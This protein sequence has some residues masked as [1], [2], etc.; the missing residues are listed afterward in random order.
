MYIG[1]GRAHDQLLTGGRA[2][3]VGTNSIRRTYSRQ[4]GL[5]YIVDN[6]G[7]IVNAVS[8]QVWS[9]D[10]VVHV[11]IVNWIKGIHVGLKTLAV[12]K[13]DHVASQWEVFHPARINSSLSPE[14]DLREARRLDSNRSTK[15]C[16]QGQTH[17]NN[18]FLIPADEARLLLTKYPEIP[19]RAFPVS[20]RKRPCCPNG[21]ASESICYRLWHIQSIRSEEILRAIRESQT[22]RS[23]SAHSIRRER[24]RSEREKRSH[25]TQ[26]PA[27][28][29]TM[30]NSSIVGGNYHTAGVA[31]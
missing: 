5:D 17:G 4:G 16:F 3:L 27:S 13:G 21:L 30:R 12:Q 7:A 14:I 28:T 1:F 22:R 29:L 11:S 9:G 8:S 18:G 2:G 24:T 15:L 6:G 26:R 19:Q 23:P 20:N 31:C 10:A 25:P